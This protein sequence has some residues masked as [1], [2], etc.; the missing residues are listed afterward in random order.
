[1]SWASERRFSYAFGAAAFLL[2][3]VGG[4]FFILYYDPATCTD[5]RQNGEEAGVDCGGACVRLC[6]FEVAPLKVLWSRSFEV[7]PG[8]YNAVAYVENPNR[9]AGVREIKY[10]FR[11]VDQ[12]NTIIVEREGTTFITP[13]GISPVFESD[14][15]TGDALPARTFFEFLEEPEW[16]R[17]QGIG[18]ALSVAS[19]RLLD[20]GTRPRIDATLVNN[21][22]GEYKDI[23]VVGVVFAADGNA[24]AASRTV[25]NLLSKNA[26]TPI[27]FTWPRP[28]ER[29]LEQCVVPADVVLAIDTSGSMNDLGGTPPQ[30]ISDAKSAAASFVS[31]LEEDDLVGVVSFATAG[32]LE[33]DPTLEHAEV[34][35][36][37][38]NLAILPASETGRT[39]IAD[40]VKLGREALMR[41]PRTENHSK[42]IVLLTDGRANAP[43]ERTAESLALEEAD[44]AKLNEVAIYTIGLGDNVNQDF[45]KNLASTPAHY[46]PAATSKEL[47]SIYREIST[48]IC[49]RGPAVIDIVPRT[50]EGLV[51]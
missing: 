50:K 26:S 34:R 22:L 2:L 47:E 33:R 39:N 7:S 28:F 45:L 20:T 17:A 44:R 13:N 23:E 16:Y 8:R 14:I 27:V 10:I 31:R 11:V 36:V 41:S 48:A 43:S 29:R 15:R 42:V 18:Q 37:V 38:E 9:H 46:F 21:S 40:G 30:P 12:A 6:E 5:G 32:K 35:A 3:L 51:P 24:V 1:M 49:E 4:I 25:V 19:T